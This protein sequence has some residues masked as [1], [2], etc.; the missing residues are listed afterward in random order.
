MSTEVKIPALGES[1][2][3]GVLSSW[4]VAE[5]SYVDVDQ[6]IYELETDKITQ[7]GLAEVAGVISFTAQEGEEVEIGATI[8]NIDESAEK[9]DSSAPA[10]EEEPAV[11]SADAESKADPKLAPTAVPVQVET[12]VKTAEPSSS[13]LPFSPAV[14]KILS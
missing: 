9:S 14:R 12:D 8:A 10:A 6:P 7:E 4:K 5:G 1:I 3:S 13:E 11:E 2:S